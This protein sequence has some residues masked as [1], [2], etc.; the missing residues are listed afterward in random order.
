MVR[1]NPVNS[2]EFVRLSDHGSVGAWLMII[3]GALILIP[4]IVVAVWG[5]IDKITIKVNDR[6]W[7]LKANDQKV[8]ATALF[9]QE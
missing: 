2:S 9:G 8:Y 7:V 5:P 1:Y 3:L 6:K 4:A